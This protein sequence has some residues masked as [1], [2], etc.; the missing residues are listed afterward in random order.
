MSKDIIRCAG[1]DMQYA[2]VDGKLIVV[3]EVLQCP[4][5]GAARPILR[6]DTGVILNGHFMQQV[7][8]TDIEPGK[9][10]FHEETWLGYVKND[11]RATSMIRAMLREAGITSQKECNNFGCVADYWVR[12]PRALA[13]LERTIQR[14]QRIDEIGEA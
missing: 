11:S 12:L 1:C 6:D 8:R 14:N 13:E 4:V 9:H 10:K 7:L 3:M 2:R 5:C